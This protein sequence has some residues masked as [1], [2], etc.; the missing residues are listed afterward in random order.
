MRK[1]SRAIFK[2]PQG[3]AEER[4][5]SKL[6][7]QL[8]PKLDLLKIEGFDVNGNRY[9]EASLTVPWSNK[10]YVL[11][12]YAKDEME[13]YQAV[14]KTFAEKGYRFDDVA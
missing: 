3:F 11:R 7:Q 2:E 14:R 10:P 12:G 1:I 4:P 5:L 9:F 6:A 8:M 13:V